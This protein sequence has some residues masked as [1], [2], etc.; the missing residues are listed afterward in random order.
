MYEGNVIDIPHEHMPRLVGVYEQSPTL[1]EQECLTSDIDYYRGCNFPHY[2]M[3]AHSDHKRSD[4]FNQSHVC[5]TERVATC[6]A[7]G[8]SATVNGGL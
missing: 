3:H 4:I 1:L 6:V 8:G 2:I 7:P 5:R